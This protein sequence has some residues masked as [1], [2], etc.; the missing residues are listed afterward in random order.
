MGRRTLINIIIILI[1]IIAITIIIIT[2]NNI[3]IITI[4]ITTAAGPLHG[5]AL[6][7]LDGSGHT[8]N[9]DLLPAK[10][11]S[12]AIGFERSGGGE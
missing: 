7:H 10:I 3:I 5:G 9:G 6:R 4:A 2:T 8:S 11:L 12:K 1:L